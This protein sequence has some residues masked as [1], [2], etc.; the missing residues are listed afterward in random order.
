MSITLACKVPHSLRKLLCCVSLIT[1]IPDW[2]FVSSQVRERRFRRV[3]CL[4]P[5]QSREADR[6]CRRNLPACTRPPGNVLYF[7]NDFALSCHPISDG[8]ERCTLK[9]FVKSEY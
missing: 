1:T 8:R 3:I 6:R 5:P 9:R 2:P 7:Q 4:R